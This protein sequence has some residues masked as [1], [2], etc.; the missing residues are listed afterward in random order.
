MNKNIEPMSILECLTYDYRFERP[1]FFRLIFRY[2]FQQAL[3]SVVDYRLARYFQL[4]GFKFLTVLIQNFS[5]RS[6]G[7]EIN[8]SAIIGPGLKLPHPNGVVIGHGVHIAKNVT[9]YQQVTLGGKG[10]KTDVLPRYPVIGENTI[11][12]A[13]AKIVG[14]VNVG[15]NAVVGANSVV[16]KD[17]ADGET[18]A[19]VP[20][21]V[22]KNYF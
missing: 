1:T 17:V 6:T 19:G 5:Y 16:T 3:R 15:K 20:A 4:K 2:F 18:V 7:A 8:T 9:I 11:I 10:R 13:G 14:A 12:Y 21:R 22:I